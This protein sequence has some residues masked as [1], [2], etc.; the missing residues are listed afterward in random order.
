[1]QV[2]FLSASCSLAGAIV[3]LD[4]RDLWIWQ[5][6]QWIVQAGVGCSE[7]CRCEGCKNMYGRKEGNVFHFYLFPTLQKVSVP[8]HED[9]SLQKYYSI[10]LCLVPQYSIPG[11]VLWNCF[12]YQC[13][14]LAT[15]F[16]RVVS[17]CMFCKY[18]NKK[19]WWHC[20]SMGSVCQIQDCT[21]QLKCT[22][23]EKYIVL[24]FAVTIL[25]LYDAWKLSVTLRS[26]TQQFHFVSF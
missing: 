1:M 15:A 24:C 10:C 2:L 19:I 6:H 14:A 22:R 3:I 13:P 18:H 16:V 5:K 17:K 20:R 11:I 25:E 9:C 26:S 21:V 7:G 4:V 23:F 12:L 8:H